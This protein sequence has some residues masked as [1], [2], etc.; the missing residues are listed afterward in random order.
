MTDSTGVIFW[1][2]DTEQSR[3]IRQCVIYDE[4]KKW[5]QCDRSDKSALPREQN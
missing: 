2:Y 1:E 5:Q 4:D 3:P